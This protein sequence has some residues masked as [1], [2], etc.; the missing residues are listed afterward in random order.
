MGWG[1]PCLAS[2][3]LLLL[4]SSSCSSSSFLPLFLFLSLLLC[5]FLSLFLL[6]FL[7][8]LPFLPA[9]L[10]PLERGPGCLRRPMLC[11]ASIRGMRA[12]VLYQAALNR[13]SLASGSLHVSEK[14]SLQLVGCACVKQLGP[15]QLSN[16]ALQLAAKQKAD[17]RRRPDRPHWEQGH[18][19][20]LRWLQGDGTE[21][22]WTSQ[23]KCRTGKRCLAWLRI[24]GP[25]RKARDVVSGVLVDSC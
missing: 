5:H 10:P 17:P 7:L 11:M 4:L 24:P 9:F 15:K 25:K 19:D 12:L 18:R 22:T 16:S 13:A 3:L 21:G 1:P 14:L 23:H 8:L 6:L 20:I 2:L